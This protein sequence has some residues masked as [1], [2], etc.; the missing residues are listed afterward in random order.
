MDTILAF[1][2]NMSAW[3]WMSFGVALLSFELM[4]P[5]ILMGWVSISA[6]LTAVIVYLTGIVG[7][8]AIVAFLVLGAGVCVLKKKC[9]N[10]CSKVCYKKGS[11]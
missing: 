3:H 8:P 9:P 2:M 1:I 11:N 7:L 10:M 4:F 6:F 5:G